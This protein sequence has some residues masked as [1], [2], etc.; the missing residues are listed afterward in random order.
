MSALMSTGEE[1]YEKAQAFGRRIERYVSDLELFRAMLQKQ[2]DGVYLYQDFV[3]VEPDLPSRITV[4][5]RS[6]ILWGQETLDDGFWATTELMAA[7]HFVQLGKDIC[8]PDRIGR[9]T[10]T[11]LASAINNRK[12]TEE[13]LVMLVNV[14]DYMHRVSDAPLVFKY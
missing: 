13:E 4:A 10:L 6:L 3:G 1:K 5:I 2:E 9:A 7:E 11:Q 8:N 12:L 14:L